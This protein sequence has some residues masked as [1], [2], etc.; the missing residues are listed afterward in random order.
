M[1]ALPPFSTY[2]RILDYENSWQPSISGSFV[3]KS[4]KQ[5]WEISYEEEDAVNI[6][7]TSEAHIRIDSF[8]QRFLERL[9][10]VNDYESL[11]S[12]T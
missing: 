3:S 7:L 1:N 9:V 12:A 4:L 5:L 6:V 10:C 2:E 8:A 11:R